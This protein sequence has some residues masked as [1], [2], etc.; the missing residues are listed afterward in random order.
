MMRSAIYEGM[1]THVRSK[2][3]EHRLQYGLFSLLIDLDELD[4]LERIPLFSHNRTN[5]VSFFDRDHGP[6]D[7]S[8]LRPW[9]TARLREAGFEETP[10]RIRL[11][12]LPRILGYEFNPLTI[13]FIDAGDGSPRWLLYEIH[14][15]FGEAHSHLVEIDDEE[16]HRHGF[17]K[18]FF[19]SPFFDVAGGYR[20]RITQPRSTMSV[21]ITYEVEGERVFTATLVG[22]RRPLTT[23]T[24]LEAVVRY[25]LLTFKVM[26]A[27]HWEAAKL[28]LKG[29]RYRKRP[30]PPDTDV[31][32]TR[33]A[34]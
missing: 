32:L 30:D 13:W 15:T 20:V 17:R 33:M 25:P 28:W 10:G 1:T 5:I 2:P 19:V 24:L 27:I 6:R 18:E 4:D 31:S 7:G 23:K 11:L 26:A 12:C 21:A 3:V 16:Q 29:A 34:A 14:N 8:E 9:I 22:K